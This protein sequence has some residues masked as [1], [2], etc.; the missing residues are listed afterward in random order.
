MKDPVFN[1]DSDKCRIWRHKNSVR[2]GHDYRWTNAA[3]ITQ[4]KLG[5]GHL[6]EGANLA[7]IE[8]LFWESEV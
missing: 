7:R 6:L 3:E 8:G 4:L 1:L 5:G 2:K